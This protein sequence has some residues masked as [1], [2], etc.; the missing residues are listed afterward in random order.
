MGVFKALFGIARSY[1]RD[2]RTAMRYNYQ[3]CFLH[4]SI[5]SD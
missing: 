5:F 3:G 2:I 1:Q 4:P